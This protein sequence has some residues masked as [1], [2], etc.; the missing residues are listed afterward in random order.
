MRSYHRSLPQTLT[1]MSTPEI[2]W[3]KAGGPVHELIIPLSVCAAHHLNILI[4]PLRPA[5][6]DSH[7]GMTGHVTLQG[8]HDE[9]DISQLGCAR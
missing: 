5:E 6:S 1:K 8:G 9:T 4:V 2:R 3:G 7:H